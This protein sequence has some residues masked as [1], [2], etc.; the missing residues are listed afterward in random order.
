MALNSGA[1][2]SF[3]QH[4]GRSFGTQK[5]VVVNKPGTPEEV[6]NELE[7]QVQSKKAFFDVDA[8]VHEG[9]RMELPDPRGGTRAVWITDVDIAQVGGQMSSW[10]SHI[11]ATISDHEPHTAMPPRP[12]VI[13][14]DQIVITGSHV[15]VATHGG[16][17]SQQLPVTSGYEDLARAVKEALELLATES[18]LDEDDRNTAQEASATVL[19]EIVTESPDQSRV[20]KALAALRD[21]LSS[22]TNAAAAAAASGL[23]QQ[24]VLRH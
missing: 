6:R 9:D 5:V 10:M 14:G 22:T 13:H 17:V 11:E 8:P 16:S 23:V 19:E 3:I 12:Q 2:G 21:V 24:L 1:G 7:A 20:K 18:T 15:N 4:V